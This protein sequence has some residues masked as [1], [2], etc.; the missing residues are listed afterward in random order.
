MGEMG[1]AS[2]PA[3]M[4]IDLLLSWDSHTL[5]DPSFNLDDLIDVGDEL[6]EATCGGFNLMDNVGD[7]GIDV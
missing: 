5:Q 4:N 2:I 3:N 7:D 1:F 6:Q